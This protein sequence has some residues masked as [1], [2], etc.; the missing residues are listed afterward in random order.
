MTVV[1]LGQVQ[2]SRLLLPLTRGPST[3][4]LASLG[5]PHCAYDCVFKVVLK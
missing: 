5:R 1:P 4:G 2:Q 3:E